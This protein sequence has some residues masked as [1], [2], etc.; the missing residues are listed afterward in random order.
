MKLLNFTFITALS[1][2][3]VSLSVGDEPPIK[4]PQALEDIRPSVIAAARKAGAASA[5]RD[6]KDGNLRI[7][8]F[9]SP[10]PPGKRTDSDTGY[11][12]Y[13]VGGCVVGTPFV[14]E[15]SAYNKV[16]R[17]WHQKHK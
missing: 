8:D 16:M 2:A 17:E 11:P 4:S 6:I 7:L 5:E 15:V 9:G 14:E 1:F 12:L 10:V 3:S 13:G